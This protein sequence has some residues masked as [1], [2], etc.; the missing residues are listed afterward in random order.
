MIEKIQ[1]FSQSTRLVPDV[2]RRVRVVATTIRFVPPE[3]EL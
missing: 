2:W 3:D 1:E